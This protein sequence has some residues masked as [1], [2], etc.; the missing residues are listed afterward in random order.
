M[1]S[2]GPSP[3]DVHA[4]GWYRGQTPSNG[5]ACAGHTPFQPGAPCRERDPAP[6]SQHSKPQSASRAAAVGQVPG[7]RHCPRRSSVALLSLVT[8][9]RLTQTEPRGR[10]QGVPTET[11][12]P[13]C[14]LKAPH[15]PAGESH[16][17]RTPSSSCG[18]PPPKVTVLSPKVPPDHTGSGHSEALSGHREKEMTK[19]LPCLSRPQTLRALEPPWV[20]PGPAPRNSGTSSQGQSSAGGASAAPIAL[21]PESH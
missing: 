9:G 15:Q 21:M 19:V 17:P 5:V 10:W 2:R 4:W 14:P 11:D 13:V 12:Q 6:G 3:A 7:D 20:S 18:Q 8:G 16:P 1:A